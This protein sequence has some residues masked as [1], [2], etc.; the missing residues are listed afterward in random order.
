MH[1]T[2]P[3]TRYATFFVLLMLLA[4]ENV[5]R[6]D[7]SSMLLREVQGGDSAIDVRRLGNADAAS[8]TSVLLQKNV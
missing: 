4:G 1:L 3:D 5:A 6:G 2:L 8:L 7:N